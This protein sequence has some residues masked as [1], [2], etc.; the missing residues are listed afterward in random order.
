MVNAL[1]EQNDADRRDTSSLK[2]IEISGSNVVVSV[3]QSC[4]EKLKA[5]RAVEAFGM[6]EGNCILGMQYS[7]IPEAIPTKQSAGK[8]FPGARVKVRAQGTRTPVTR[9]EIGELHIAGV[10]TI[11]G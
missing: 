9:G 1:V 2:L 6:S 7:E 4:R 5:D 11:A 10:Q 8:V 3:V